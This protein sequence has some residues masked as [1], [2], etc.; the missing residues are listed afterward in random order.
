MLGEPDVAE[1]E[2]LRGLRDLDAARIDLLGR[3]RRRRL[4]QQER[5]EFHGHLERFRYQ[6]CGCPGTLTRMAY[7]DV[8]AVKNR[9]VRSGPPKAR[10]AGISGVRMIPRRVPSGAKTQVPPGPVQYT[11]PSTST[12]MPSGTP[13]VSSDDIS[14]KIRRRT[15]A[16]AASSSNAWMYCVQ[17]VLAT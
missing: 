7:T 6:G 2:A 10:F 3:A 9:V 16:P 1:A 12:F 5:A 8:R 4:H 13:S 15:T 14:A 11:R 17:R